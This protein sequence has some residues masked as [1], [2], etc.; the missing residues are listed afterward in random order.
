MPHPRLIVYCRLILLDGAAIGILV[1]FD[2]I[3]GFIIAWSQ[4]Q[5][6]PENQV[7]AWQKVSPV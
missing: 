2:G 1:R 3:R 6:T 5:D 7:V 4:S